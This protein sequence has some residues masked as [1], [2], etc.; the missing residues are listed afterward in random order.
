MDY[1]FSEILK[2][3]IKEYYVKYYRDD[4]S[5][6][7]FDQ[8]AET[9]VT[10]EVLET[11]RLKYLRDHMDIDLNNKSVCIVGAGTG[12]LAVVLYKQYHAV[13]Y[14]VEPYEPGLNIIKQKCEE[15]GMN[16]DNF[17]SNSAEVLPFEDDQFDVVYCYTVLEH[18]QNIEKAIDEMIRVSKFGGVIYINTPNYSLPYERHYKILFP[19]FLPKWVGYLYLIL[20]GKSPV[21]LQTI[22]YVTEKSI[23]KILA[24]KKGISWL[25]LYTPIKQ[26]VKGKTAKVLLFFQ[27]YFSF[28]S[29]QDILIRKINNK[30]NTNR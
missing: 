30:K 1:N 6:S 21:F 25:R 3:K 8:L 9:R 23:N 12:G 29:H 24:G 7:R 11:K 2:Q 15:M 4:C 13:V 26:N 27:R 19:T 10:E 14:G 20:L 17:L 28:Y 22:N 16:P 5:I 18:V